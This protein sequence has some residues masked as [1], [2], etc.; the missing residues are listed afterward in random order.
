MESF[1]IENSE[2]YFRYSAMKYKYTAQQRNLQNHLTERIFNL[3]QQH[4][5]D[6]YDGTV[7]DFDDFATIKKGIRSFYR[8]YGKS[9]QSSSSKKRYSCGSNVKFG[10]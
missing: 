2:D 5:Y 8:K 4:G 9:Q 1:L 3:A 6:I 10:D 7:D